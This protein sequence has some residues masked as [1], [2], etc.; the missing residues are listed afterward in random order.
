MKTFGIRLGASSCVAEG[1]ADDDPGGPAELDAQ[2]P[3]HG[4]L[5][6]MARAAGEH[7][8]HFFEKLTVISAGPR[9]ELPSCLQHQQGSSV[10]LAYQGNAGRW[11]DPLRQMRLLQQDMNRLMDSLRVPAPPEFPL[12]NI[13]TGPDGAVITA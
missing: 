1:V 8:R 9:A 11:F 2:A 6:P 3:A 5:R 13:W 12:I 10:M 4:L 7:L